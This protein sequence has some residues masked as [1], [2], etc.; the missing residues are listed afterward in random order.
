M[1]L[2]QSD[3]NRLKAHERSMKCICNIP[4]FELLASHFVKMLFRNAGK[5]NQCYT[6][7]RQHN[8]YILV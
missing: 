2:M 3:E 5:N 4:K 8:L 6:N 7:V 1:E